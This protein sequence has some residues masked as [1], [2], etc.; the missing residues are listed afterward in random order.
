MEG[1]SCHDPVAMLFKAPQGSKIEVKLVSFTSGVA[2]D[3]CPYAGVEIKAQ[4]D[5]KFTGYRS[6]IFLNGYLSFQMSVDISL[7][8]LC[9]PQDAGVSFVSHHHII[10]I[11][12]YNRLYETRTVL[13]YRVGKIHTS[14]SNIHRRYDHQQQLSLKRLGMHSRLRNKA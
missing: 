3:G 4:R 10:P 12:T 14:S 13:Q 8:R 11:I 1:V 6:E 5:Q 7:F 2:N 9:S